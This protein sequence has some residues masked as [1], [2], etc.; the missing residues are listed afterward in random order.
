MFCGGSFQDTK[1]NIN[2]TS[3]NFRF[4]QRAARLGMSIGFC[5]FGSKALWLPPL[6]HIPLQAW[7]WHGL[8]YQKFDRFDTRQK[9]ILTHVKSEF[10]T[11]QILLFFP[12]VLDGL[13]WGLVF[14]KFDTRR[15]FMFL[16]MYWL[17]CK[18]SKFDT[19]QKSFLKTI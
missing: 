3:R 1:N 14:E 7:L 9:T 8:P 4:F 16:G 13:Y 15:I 10:D 11:R 19:R 2:I 18:F 17:I 5:E 12:N 6:V